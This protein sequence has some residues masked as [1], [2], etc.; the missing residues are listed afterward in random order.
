MVAILSTGTTVLLFG[1]QALLFN[2]ESLAQLRAALLDSPD[3]CWALK[4]IAEFSDYWGAILEKFPQLQS[5]AGSKL[6]EDLKQWLETGK[7]THATFPLPN[8]LLTPLT[9]IGQLVQ[10]SRYLDAQSVP[11]DHEN[12]F[13]VFKQD[14]QT[15]GHCTGLLSAFAVASSAS[16]VQFEHYS[17]VA[18]R[19]AMLIGALV[20]SKDNSDRGYGPSRSLA[21]VWN[22]PEVGDELTRV[23]DHFPE[24]SC[25][26]N[27]IAFIYRKG[28]LIVT[29]RHM[30]QSYMMT[31]V[32]LSQFL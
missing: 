25:F 17:S 21:T 30:L 26:A 16:R 7:L 12:L 31:I 27:L 13:S 32:L 6:V 3:H 2:E 20:D 10:Y 28:G 29:C 23:L 15:L 4:T 9:V 18:V 24:V 19:Q 14:T 5:I 11:G 22:S 8:I 1:S